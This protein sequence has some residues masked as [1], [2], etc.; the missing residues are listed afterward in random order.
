MY[1]AILSL[2]SIET[3]ELAFD[4]D[5]QG[6]WQGKGREQAGFQPS[7]LAFGLRE[8]SQRFEFSQSLKQDLKSASATIPEQGKS[9]ER[10][11]T[12]GHLNL[13]STAQIKDELGK[14]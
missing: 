4:S 10:S 5:L 11:Y 13:A 3:A 9:G 14:E 6:Q 1:L 7:Q 12:A 8:K 2:W